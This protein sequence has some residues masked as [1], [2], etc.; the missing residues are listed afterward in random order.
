MNK[1]TYSL[2]EAAQILG[3]SRATAY[4]LRAQGKIPTV[5]DW[6]PYRVSGHWLE[7]QLGGP[8][9]QDPRTESFHAVVNRLRQTRGL[10]LEAVSA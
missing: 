5:G 6:T 8:I 3:M 2:E 9:F 4:E 1:N 7:Q 10:V